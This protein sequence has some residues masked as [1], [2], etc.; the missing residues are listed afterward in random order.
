LSEG[1]PKRNKDIAYEVPMSDYQFKKYIEQRGFE[2][3]KEKKYKQ[4]ENSGVYKIFSRATCNFVFPSDIPRPFPGENRSY[5]IDELDKQ[6]TEYVF[7]LEKESDSVKKD[8][9]SGVLK[10]LSDLS[11]RRSDYLVIDKG[12]EIYSPKYNL[13]L[14]NIIS[15]RG[16]SIVYSDFR[17]VEGLETLGT[18]FRANDFGQIQV[19]KNGATYEIIYNDEKKFHYAKYGESEATDHILLKIFNYDLEGLPK[20]ILKEL[21]HIN[22]AKNTIDG[23]FI[24][25]LMITRSGSE[26]ISLK[27]VRNVHILEPYWNNIRLSQVIGRANRLNS[28]IDLPVAERNFTVHKYCAIFSENQKDKIKSS[29]IVSDQNKTSDQIIRAIADRKSVLISTF[30]KNIKEAS[31]DC[32]MHKVEEEVNSCIDI[33][34]DNRK[35][36]TLSN[37]MNRKAYEFDLESEEIY[38]KPLRVDKKFQTNSAY[39]VRILK[40]SPFSKE[41]YVYIPTSNALYDYE[42]TTKFNAMKNFKGTMKQISKGKYYVNLI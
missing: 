14:K 27:N 37:I 19:K 42:N 5:V 25:V 10:A 22:T 39:I 24:K 34:K 8:Y 23:G 3:E 4:N 33:K 9:K 36:G 32:R 2:I 21:S 7:S 16:T 38:M 35:T 29:K 30:L 20:N 18:S 41:K 1:Y 13:L 17:K 40:E 11:E 12:L 26:G 31:I 15:S 6:S 28:H